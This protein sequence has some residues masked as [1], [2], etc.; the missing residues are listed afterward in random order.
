MLLRHAGGEEQEKQKDKG[1]SSKF[2]K[3]GEL[4]KQK[5]QR[6]NEGV[7]NTGENWGENINGTNMGIIGSTMKSGA[8][9]AFAKTKDDASSVKNKFS[10][11]P[12]DKLCNACALRGREALWQEGMQGMSCSKKEKVARQWIEIERQRE[13]ERRRRRLQRG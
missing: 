9:S 7:K 8:K 2:G 10:K 12:E 4:I 6:A 5:S 13:E 11:A 1:P 3:Y